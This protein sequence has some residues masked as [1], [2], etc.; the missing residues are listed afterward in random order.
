MTRDDTRR[1]FANPALLAGLAGA[2]ALAIVALFGARRMAGHYRKGSPPSDAARFLPW[3]DRCSEIRRGLR[4]VAHLG[5]PADDESLEF[6]V[7]AGAD[8]ALDGIDGVAAAQPKP[9]VVVHPGASEKARRWAPSGFAQV[10][11]TLAGA[12]YRIVLTGTQAERELTACVAGTMANPALD[13]AGRT[14]LD[15]LSALVRRASLVVCNDTGVSHLAAALA[16]PSVVVFRASDV[17]RWAPLDRRLHRPVAGSVRHVLSE[18]RRLLR[19][20][21]RDAA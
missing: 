9:F 20:T 16:V 13:L 18:A 1:L 10:A 7:G 15:G 21:Q 6:P 19:G 5:W 11:D 17:D 2:V 14:S 8:V 12:G 3:V 4:L